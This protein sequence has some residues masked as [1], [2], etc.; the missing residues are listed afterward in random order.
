MS[1]TGTESNGKPRVR[2]GKTR[3]RALAALAGVG[4]LTAV[5]VIVEASQN[6]PAAPNAAAAKKAA[7]GAT[8]PV[9]RGAKVTATP[10][11][12]AAVKAAM[13]GTGPVVVAFLLP[14]M[15][16]DE[17][18]QKR[19]N[20]LQKESKFS[21]TKFVVYRITTKT[22][23]GDLPT[24]FDVKYTPAVAVIQGDDKLSN[25]WRGLVDEDI[26][27]QSLLDARAAV[28]KPVKTTK[29]AAGQPTGSPAGIA[30]AKK[31]NAAY[32]KVPGV[33]MAGTINAP[34]LGPV[35]ADLSVKLSNGTV[36]AMAADLKVAGKPAKMYT[37]ATGQYAMLAGGAC[38]I[39][40]TKASDV[41]DIGEPMLELGGS[42]FGKPVKK[43]ASWTLQVVEDGSNATATIDAKT[44]QLTELTFDVSGQKATVTVTALD[45]TPALVKPDKVC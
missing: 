43:G 20:A 30:L 44:H 31:V 10:K 6:A 26:I 7:A 35:D 39:R 4:V 42:K 11:T 23:L 41:D 28:P 36:Q 17:I 27:A 9:E 12:P 8:T 45:K 3:R 21:D 13:K 18:V 29:K 14:G 5:P 38:W 34:G 32:A 22:K 1:P 25:V 33:T 15:T 19:L 16:E 40:S 2:V 24:L 37:D